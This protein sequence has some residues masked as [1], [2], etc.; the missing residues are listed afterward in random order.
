MKNGGRRNVRKHREIKGRD[1]Y[2]T[3]YI[4]LKFGSLNK[5]RITSLEPNDNLVISEKG[6]ITSLGLK[7][8][9]MPKKYKKARC[10]IKNVIKKDLSKIIKEFDKLTYK[11][12]ER[13]RPKHKPTDSYFYPKIHLCKVYDE[14]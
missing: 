14:I 4:S 6:L 10:A 8:K 13:R 11:S 1:K 9:S 2:V 7:D 5:M 3:L 12:Y